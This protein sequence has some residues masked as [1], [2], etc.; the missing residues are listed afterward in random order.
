MSCQIDNAGRRRSPVLTGAH[1]SPVL[2]GAHKKERRDSD[3]GTGSP[4]LYLQTLSS[5]R[6]PLPLLSF[7]LARARFG[8]SLPPASVLPCLPSWR[9]EALREGGSPPAR[10]RVGGPG[11]LLPH[12]SLAT[13]F[14]SVHFANGNRP[15]SMKT[16]GEKNFNRYTSKTFGAPVTPLAR[17]HPGGSVGVPVEQMSG[18][19]TIRP[20]DARKSGPRITVACPVRD[21]SF[22]PTGNPGITPTVERLIS[23]AKTGT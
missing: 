8:S 22:P 7:H 6:S 4:G 12:S 3:N 18:N 5:K 15:N 20:C 16:R 2:A 19:P 17:R 21:S 23:S 14:Q 1:E 11:T 10:H 9:A 13:V